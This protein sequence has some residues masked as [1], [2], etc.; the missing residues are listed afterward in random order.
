MRRSKIEEI[1]LTRSDIPFG[2]NRLFRHALAI[3]GYTNYYF[4]TFIR[5]RLVQALNGGVALPVGNESRPHF[6]IHFSLCAQPRFYAKSSFQAFKSE[7]LR[8][9]LGRMNANIVFKL[10][11]E[12]PGQRQQSSSLRLSSRSVMGIQCLVTR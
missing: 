4:S 5:A 3:G 7:N 11:S 2:N 12:I 10:L 8:H 6:V 9:A 1:R